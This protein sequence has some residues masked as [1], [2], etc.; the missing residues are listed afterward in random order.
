MKSINAVDPRTDYLE[1]DHIT[2]IKSHQGQFKRFKN[3]EDM[4]YECRLSLI[5]RCK[6]TG[7]EQR[8][9]IYYIP[10]DHTSLSLTIIDLDGIARGYTKDM[11]DVELTYAYSVIKPLLSDRWEALLGTGE[12]SLDEYN[13]KFESLSEEEFIEIS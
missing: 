9:N 4:H 10:N 3:S 1:F 5:H 2:G 6:L 7:R 13:L 11:D 8:N 12:I